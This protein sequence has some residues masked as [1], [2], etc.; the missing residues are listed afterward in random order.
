MKNF[1][2]V[3]F[4]SLSLAYSQDENY[5][6]VTPSQFRFSLGYGFAALNPKEVNEH[7]ANSN[8]QMS[9]TAKSIKS[10]PEI[11]GML[12]FFP[13]ASSALITLR[14]GYL[15]TERN[16]S[17]QISETNNNG[18]E[19]G[20]VN[21]AL[22]ET[23][24]AYPFAIGVGLTNEKSTLQLHFEFIYALGYIAEEGSYTQSNSRRTN[25]SNSYFSPTYGF[26]AAVGVNA[27]ITKQIGLGFELGYRYMTFNEF[28]NEIT[29]QSSLLE[30]SM[31]GI[32]GGVRLNINL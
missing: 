12:T 22:T 16:Y 5:Q 27:P 31:N 20:K 7:I 6:D 18:A 19:I 3:F 2:F 30:F 29:A 10:M 14:G 1:S 15:W 13:D 24:S 26:R 32:Q 25:F 11:S 8:T 21:G 17:F 9:S 23:Y 28:E 4:L